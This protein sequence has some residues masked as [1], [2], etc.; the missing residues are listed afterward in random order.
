M[1][2]RRLKN[3]TKISKRNCRRLSTVLRLLELKPNSKSMT[4]L[5]S[6]IISKKNLVI[7]RL[8]QKSQQRKAEIEKEINNLKKFWEKYY[9][10]D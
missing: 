9:E 1:N 7:E 5:Y 3:K 2:S 8:R 10:T 4:Y 6:E